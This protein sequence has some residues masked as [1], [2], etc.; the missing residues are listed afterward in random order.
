MVYIAEFIVTLVFFGLSVFVTQ[1]MINTGAIELATFP[2]APLF[3]IIIALTVGVN[4]VTSY[5]VGLII[6]Y[7]EMKDEKSLERLLEKS[8][9]KALEPLTEKVDK[10]NSKIDKVF[11]NQNQ[12][13]G[14]LREKGTIEKTVQI[15][16]AV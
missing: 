3:A 1:V 11:D 6:E 5:I 14:E 7:K 2:F 16:T 13:I 8:L 15:P 9:E 12:L 10:G 4:K